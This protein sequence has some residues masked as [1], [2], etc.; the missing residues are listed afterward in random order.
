NY[1]NKNSKAGAT[2]NDLV[3]WL[4]KGGIYHPVRSRADINA[5]M[6]FTPSHLVRS[7]SGQLAAEFKR[8][9]GNGTRDL[10]NKLEIMKDKGT[11]RVDADIRIRPDVS[12]VENFLYLNKLTGNSR[13]LV[14]V[15][16]SVQ[17]FVSFTERE[18]ATFFW[19]RGV[20]KEKLVQL[21][22][23]DNTTITSVIDLDRWISGKEPGFLIKNFIADV[24]PQ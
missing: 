11:V 10:Y 2:A 15:T 6:P 17:P 20:L 8:M 5:S 1:P 18:L 19:K 23:M 21:G 12:V 16:S 24:A 3:N 14:P 13:R 7:V 9:Y 4:V 22:K